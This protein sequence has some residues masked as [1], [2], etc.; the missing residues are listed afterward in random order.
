MGNKAVSIAKAEDKNEQS[1]LSDLEL[2]KA[3]QKDSQDAFAE[4]VARYETK[5]FNLAMSLTRNIEDSEEVL[6]DVFVTVHRKISGFEGKSAFSSWLYR[7][8]V[9]ASFMKLRKRKQNK[10]IPV[11]EIT[12]QMESAWLERSENPQQRCDHETYNNELKEHLFEAINRLPEEYKSVFI[13]RDV[14]GLPNKEVSD[15]LGIT[16]PAVK[17]RLHRARIML[18]KK[19]QRFYDDMTQDKKICSPGPKMLLGV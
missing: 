16:V 7:V 9:N 13:L 1:D 14:D 8:T 12:P 18:K 17:S 4:L 2:I 10:S 19:L 6:Q 3:I 15:I 11:D 5:V